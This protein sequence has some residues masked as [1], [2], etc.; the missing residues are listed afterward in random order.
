M[1]RIAE[2]T[3]QEIRD[4][5]DI[6]EVVSRYLPLK[7]SGANY[8]GLCPFHQEKTPSFNVNSARQIFH[9]FG[10]GVGGNVFSFLMRMEGL[11]FPEAVRQ[12]ADKVGVEIEEHEKS[13]E[14]IRRLESIERL[15]RINEAAGEFYHQLLLKENAGTVGRKYLRARGYEG[16]T[17]RTFRLG[18]APEGWE[19]LKNN[20]SSKFATADLRRTGLLR[21]GKQGRGDYDLFRNRLLFPIHDLKGRIVAFGGRVLDDSLPK[22]INSPETEL[23]HKGKVL[24]GLHQARESIRQSDQVMVVEGYFD[25]LALHQA[26]FP[27]TVATCGTALTQD[28]A[29]LLKRFA[30]KI[31]LI[32][33]QDAAGINAMFRAMDVLLPSG[34]TVSVVM[35]PAGEDPDSLVNSKGRNGFQSFLD[36]AR[37]VL[38]VFIEKQLKSHDESAEGRARAA[39]QILSRL[40]LLPDELERTLYLNQLATKI[41]LT[42]E[43]LK[44]SLQL[45]ESPSRISAE[46]SSKPSRKLPNTVNVNGQTQKYLL[47]LMLVD[48]PIRQRV[49]TEGTAELFLDEQFRNLADHLLRI[50]TPD[51]LLP[52]NLGDAN[53]E[54]ALQSLLSGLAILEDRAWADDPEKIF[55]DCRRAVINIGLKKRLQEVGR[56]LEEA[57]LSKDEAMEIEYL[58][59]YSEINQRLK[60]KL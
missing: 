29:R 27:N 48:N 5:V 13:P 57:R 38:E 8:Q 28:H 12:L 49:R 18:F 15:A 21:P 10:C 37:P 22:Y 6:V 14:D 40:K 1:G 54:D 26:G 24:Y 9:C 60:K 52:D 20:L 30:N 42:V 59:E 39:K 7:R 35:L 44:S 25:V 3:I 33:D 19:T 50:E 34:L 47:R 45:G 16:E 36:A 53:L 41:G 58:R 56:L 46:R 51:G 55:E 4:R 31:L 2:E 32:F 23:Y 11:N 43:D 17:V